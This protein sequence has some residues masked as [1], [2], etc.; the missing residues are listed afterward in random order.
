MDLNRVQ[1]AELKS[2]DLDPT[3]N[4]THEAIIKGH[5]HN[6]EQHAVVIG[7]VVTLRETIK[8]KACKICKRLCDCGKG[9]VGSLTLLVKGLP[10]QTDAKIHLYT[11]PEGEKLGYPSD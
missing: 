9:E 1:I 11:N 7:S 2:G 6:C 3:P 5:K 4:G 8:L 10:V